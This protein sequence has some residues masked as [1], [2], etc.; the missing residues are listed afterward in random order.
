MN[1][2]PQQPEDSRIRIGDEAGV[3]EAA[4]LIRAG[5]LVAFPTETVYGLGANALDA[6][7]V[8]RIFEAKGRPRFDPL[9]VHVADLQK[10]RE[11]VSD[12]PD[13]AMKLAEA[14]WPGPLTLV[15]PRKSVVPDLVT[16][17]LPTVAIRV[18]DHPLA[19]AL[20]RKADRPVAA[21]SANRFGMISPTTAQHVADGLGSSVEMILD[22]GPCGTGVESTVISFGESG[23]TPTLLRPGGL[24][25]EAVEALVGKVVRVSADAHA[26]SLAP[27]APGM[28]KRHYAPTTRLILLSVGDPLPAD[29]EGAKL[30]L[31]C[32][33][34]EDVKIPPDRFAKVEA[35]SQSGDSVEAARNLFSAMRRLDASDVELIVAHRVSDDGLGLAINDRLQRASS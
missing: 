17:A 15:L 6:D 27:Q 28:L 9:I 32:M 33:R 25:V 19:L 35:L 21:P 4:R 26:E 22:G 16:S 20:L 3:N 29:C 12:I 10:A 11:L 5:R 30:G 8:A 18:P 7:A 2:Q 13:K 34:A 23:H 14:I 31:L 24:P 1:M